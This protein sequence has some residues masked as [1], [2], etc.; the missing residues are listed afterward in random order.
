[1]K[2]EDEYFVATIQDMVSKETPCLVSLS[3]YLHFRN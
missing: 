3:L 2:D 1:M